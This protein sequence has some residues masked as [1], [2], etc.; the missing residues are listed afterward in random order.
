MCVSARH[1]RQTRLRSAPRMQ[2]RAPA[3]ARELPPRTRTRP[4]SRS[5]PGECARHVL[6]SLPTGARVIENESWATEKKVYAAGEWGA[7]HVDCV[8]LDCVQEAN[9]LNAIG[10]FYAWRLGMLRW[11]LDE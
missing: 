4:S 2:D 9:R 8:D 3:R 6:I 1:R 7:W 5:R 10:A 11:T